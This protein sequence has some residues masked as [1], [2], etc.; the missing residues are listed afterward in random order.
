MC[1][2]RLEDIDGRDILVKIKENYPATNVIIITG[3]SDIRLAIELIKLG[4]YDYISK[5]LLAN[6]NLIT[7]DVLPEELKALVPAKI[8]ETAFKG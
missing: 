5:P 8:T 2:Y 3:Y 4:A 1:D 6:G 7:L